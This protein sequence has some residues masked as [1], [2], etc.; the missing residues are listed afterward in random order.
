MSDRLNDPESIAYAR[1][2]ATLGCT[3]ED[4]Y[5]NVKG[6]TYERA[7]I[8]A[9]QA[10]VERE[11]ANP[12]TIGDGGEDGEVRCGRVRQDEKRAGQGHVAAR[13]NSG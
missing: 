6:I 2:F 5:F 10:Q 1:R 11:G 7:K 12:D 9:W 4:I 13:K 8:I 3:A